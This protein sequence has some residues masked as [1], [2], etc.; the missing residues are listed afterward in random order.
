MNTPEITCTHDGTH[1]RVCTH[2][3]RHPCLPA[4]VGTRVCTCVFPWTPEVGEEELEVSFKRSPAAWSP[5]RRL[6]LPA[7]ALAST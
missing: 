1:V 4:I 6:V 5:G 7:A 3:P 2:M